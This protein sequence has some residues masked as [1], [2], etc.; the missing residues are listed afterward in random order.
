MWAIK[1]KGKKVAQGENL[2]ELC[3][4]ADNLHKDLNI[5]PTIHLEENHGKI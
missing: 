5:N 1:I 2:E 3:K 4:I